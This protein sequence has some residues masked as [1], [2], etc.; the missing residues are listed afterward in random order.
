MSTIHQKRIAIDKKLDKLEAS[1]TAF[2]NQLHLTK[3]KAVERLEL[4][5]QKLNQALNRLKSKLD[6][7]K[8][9][10]EEKKLNIRNYFENLQVQLAL[11][12][13]DTKE[14]YENQKNKIKESIRNF[15]MKVDT[16]LDIFDK[17]MDE[18]AD[19]FIEEADYLDAELDAMYLQYQIEK[20]EMKADFDA[21][22]NQA[23]DK[24]LTFKAKL[25][26]K[27]EKKKEEA[28]KAFDEMN[29]QL[30]EI[31]EPFMFFY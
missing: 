15:E 4:Q 11:G 10:A 18:T 20:A 7:S 27:R 22:K 3:D 8:T 31:T 13:A 25:K 2:E 30:S 24:I 12:K 21:K 16:E 19:Q 5:K 26:E 6:E 14:A 23:K 9:I 1:A 28:E 29:K 17:E